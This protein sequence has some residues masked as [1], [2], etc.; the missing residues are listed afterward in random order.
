MTQFEGCDMDEGPFVHGGP[1]IPAGHSYLLLPLKTH[2]QTCHRGKAE[3]KD[4]RTAIG[5]VGS[6]LSP[7]VYML[8]LCYKMISFFL[9]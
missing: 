5:L 9:Q 8:L 1:E 4:E 7:T 2:A 3:S 6:G